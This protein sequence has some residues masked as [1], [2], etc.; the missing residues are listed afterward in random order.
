MKRC[1]TCNNEK[2][3]EEFSKGYKCKPCAAEYAREMYKKHGRANQRIKRELKDKCGICGRTEA[4]EFDHIDKKQKVITIGR[5]QSAK[6]I[7]EEAKK[8]RVLCI[9]CHRVHTYAIQ[10]DETN[11]QLLEWVSEPDVNGVVCNGPVCRGMKVREHNFYKRASGKLHTT[12]INCM[13]YDSYL[14]R[15]Y[16]QTYI[17]DQKM[18][19]GK[20]QNIPSKN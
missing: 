7:I 11:N 2:P 1:V 15:R 20:C 5:E 12:C 9:W 18:N 13:A 19:I 14:K 17:N 3:N 10:Q 16:I 4:L 6:K 8:C